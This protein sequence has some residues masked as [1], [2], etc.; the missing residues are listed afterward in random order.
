MADSKEKKREIKE[1]NKRIKNSKKSKKR[2]ENNMV[3]SFLYFALFALL[4]TVVILVSVRAYD[5]GTK[6]FSEEGAEAPPG[7]DVEITVSSGDSVNDVAKKLL[8]KNV[9]E[10]KTVFAIQSKLFDADFKEGTYV[11]NTSNSAEDIIEILSA[12]DGDEES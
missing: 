7:T 3:G 8:D 10:N 2:A 1:R 6:I 4:V 12:K 5:F 11:V 9:I